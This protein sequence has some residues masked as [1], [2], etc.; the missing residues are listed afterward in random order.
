MQDLL[1]EDFIAKYTAIKLSN[2]KLLPTIFLH[3]FICSAF[4]A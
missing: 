3:T 4:F 1:N 2:I